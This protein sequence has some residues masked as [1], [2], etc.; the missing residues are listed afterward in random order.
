VEDK[1]IILGL[2]SEILK[3]DGLPLRL[4]RDLKKELTIPGI[5]W[6]DAN[7]GGLDL[8]DHLDGYDRAIIID[9]IMTRDG[10][11]GKIYTFTPEKNYRES[12][13]L[14][15]Y[16]DATF[17]VALRL[18]STLGLHLP[19]RLWIIAVEVVEGLEFGANSSRHIQDSYPLIL[20]KVSKAVSAIASE[21]VYSVL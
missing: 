21:I 4:I 2:G 16:H 7:T 20:E 13:H 5:T 1:L 17:P 14:S 18:G 15:S 19:G 3:D 6:R 10:K 11:P 9:T 12:L 8:L